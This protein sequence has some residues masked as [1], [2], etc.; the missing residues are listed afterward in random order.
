[1]RVNDPFGECT[2]KPVSAFLNTCGI[3]SKENQIKCTNDGQC[4]SGM[5]CGTEGFCVPN[6]CTTNSDCTVGGGTACSSKIG[7]HCTSQDDCDSTTLCFRNTNGIGGTCQQNPTKGQCNFCN[8]G[9]CAQNPTCAFI[10]DQGQNVVCEPGNSNTN[11]KPRD[12]SAYLAKVC[13]GRN[14]CLGGGQDVWIPNASEGNPFGPLPCE[15]QATGGS[16]EYSQLPITSGWGGGTPKDGTSSSPA[17]FK[18]GYQVDGIFCC[19]PDL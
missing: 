13:N 11:C 10:N 1:V 8:N 18:Q 17:T 3:V 2:P 14:S 9:F 16:A 5:I 6:S 15:I 7:E 4:A 12:A 19:I